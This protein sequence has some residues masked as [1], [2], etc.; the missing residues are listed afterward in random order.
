MPFVGPLSLAQRYPIHCR[1]IDVNL[2]QKPVARHHALGF[3]AIMSIFKM[4]R[5]ISMHAPCWRRQPQ[6]VSRSLSRRSWNTD[7]LRQSESVRMQTLP[8]PVERITTGTRL[9][10][11]QRAGSS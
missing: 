1:C 5:I 6:V 3:D 9:V 2:W 8:T 11:V 4:F 10:T 7:V